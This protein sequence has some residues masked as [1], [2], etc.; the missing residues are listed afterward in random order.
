MPIARVLASVTGLAINNTRHGY[1]YHFI[2]AG[3]FGARL[4]GYPLIYL[5]I[6][7]L[8]TYHPLNQ[9]SSVVFGVWYIPGILQETLFKMKCC[10]MPHISQHTKSAALVPISRVLASITRLA[11]TGHG[12]G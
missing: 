6:P 2:L 4:P 7:E 9:I 11:I 3:V 8:A 10:L 12:H 5:E 1:E